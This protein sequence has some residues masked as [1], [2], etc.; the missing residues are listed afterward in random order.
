[1]KL[2]YVEEVI[3]LKSISE[4]SYLLSVQSVKKTFSDV[5]V[6]LL[7]HLQVFVVR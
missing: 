5:N 4:H 2:S 3:K 6:V 1:M 7:L